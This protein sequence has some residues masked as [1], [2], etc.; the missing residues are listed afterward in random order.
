MCSKPKTT[1]PVQ[2]FKNDPEVARYYKPPSQ[3]GNAAEYQA[4]EEAY[5]TYKKNYTQKIQQEQMAMQSA[6][7]AAQLDAQKKQMELQKQLQE[8]QIQA[9]KEMEQMQMQMQEQ[10]ALASQKLEQQRL[11]FEKES[12]VAR[13]DSQR[14]LNLSQKA[15]DKQNAFDLGRANR[16]RKN[17]G[18]ALASKGTK[19]LQIGLNTPNANST[20]GLLIP[21]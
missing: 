20:A 21:V 18:G 11:S 8:Q 14:E 2:P 5:Y 4:W 15:A 13:A 16:N 9:Q 3:S 19:S 7:Y 10:Q 6:F 1:R 17:A 12:G